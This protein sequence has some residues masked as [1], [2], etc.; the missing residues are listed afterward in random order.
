MRE[1]FREFAAAKFRAEDHAR[2]STFQ[3]WQGA[4]FYLEGRSKK[5]MTPLKKAMDEITQSHGPQRQSEAVMK[6]MLRSLGMKEVP[7][8]GG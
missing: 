2:E 5:G 1:L 3:A 4:R 8:N 7:I 6:F